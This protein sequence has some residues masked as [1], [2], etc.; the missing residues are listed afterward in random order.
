MLDEQNQYKMSFA[1]LIDRKGQCWFQRKSK[2][3]KNF[4]SIISN[5]VSNIY[6]YHKSVADQ[7]EK[8]G[9][10]NPLLD[11]FIVQQDVAADPTYQPQH[12]APQPFSD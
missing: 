9:H 6:I 11:W 10:N 8:R 1:G 7:T 4:C 2:E 12:P 5:F 3:K